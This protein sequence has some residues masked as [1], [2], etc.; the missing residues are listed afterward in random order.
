MSIITL[1]ISFQKFTIFTLKLNEPKN[2]QSCGS[3]LKHVYNLYCSVNEPFNRG[4]LIV[5]LCLGTTLSLALVCWLNSERFIPSPKSTSVIIH[6]SACHIC[7][8]YLKT[9]FHTC[10][11]HSP[12]MKTPEKEDIY[13]R[14][15][16]KVC[17]LM[18]EVY[19]LF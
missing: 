13:L 2:V 5:L 9:V 11:L 17:S 16:R 15:V 4:C 7:F 12:H 19:P 3:V 6:C 8:H 1:H 18:G 10:H 14:N